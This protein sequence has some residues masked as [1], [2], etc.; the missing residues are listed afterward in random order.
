MLAA[1]TLEAPVD[2]LVLAAMAVA[3]VWHL[4]TGLQHSHDSARE[5]AASIWRGSLIAVLGTVLLIG[6]C[7]ATGLRNARGDGYQ[8]ALG[9][10][11]TYLVTLL[12]LVG[13]LLVVLLAPAALTL[14][15]DYTGRAMLIIVACWTSAAAALATAY[16]AFVTS[17]AVFCVSNPPTT[18]GDAS[19]A[20]ST[21]ATAA[22]FGVFGV[23]ATLPFAVRLRRHGA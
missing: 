23:V 19:C 18:A 10:P 2:L 15:R 7:S 4:R 17:Y 21:G 6:G 22:V 1:M 14:G 16:A 12:L 11:A 8:L 3:M 9:Q 13:P 5:N 20:A